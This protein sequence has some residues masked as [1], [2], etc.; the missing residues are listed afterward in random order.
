MAERVPVNVQGIV[1]ESLA[2]L[3]AS[4]PSHI[5]VEKKLEAPSWVLGDPT[6]LHQVVMN[7]CTNAIRAMEDDGVLTI[8]LDEV[9]VSE[10]RVV[11]HGT[12]LPAAYVRLAVSD[13]GTGIPPQVLE[14]IF[15]PFFTTRGVGEGTGLG[16]ALVHGIVADVQGAV[17]VLTRM[18][19]GTTFTIWLPATKESAK[20]A[21]QVARD[22]ARGAGE[23]IMIVDDELALVTLAE[24][25]L[26]ELGYEPVG[27]D[28]SVAAL[29]AFRAEPSRFDAVL[30]DETMP[31][32]AGIQLARE[33]RRLRAGPTC[34]SDERLQ[35][36]AVCGTCPGR[37]RN[38]GAAQNR[39]SESRH[40]RTR[41][42]ERCPQSGMQP[43]RPS[44]TALAP[45]NTMSF[46][47]YA[48]LLRAGL[49]LG[50]PEHRK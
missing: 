26:A 50:R 2:L 3:A 4:L 49:E 21:P 30:T 48:R 8:A 29:Q 16:L 20:A 36:R 46:G 41:S 22:L 34:H 15:D 9:Q 39:S 6:Q 5:R 18:G 42:R 19:K 14:R 13:T 44:P 32:L 43:D 40:R 7:L 33:V 31:E 23:C 35:R 45:A 47:P 37:R 24:E 25:T 27:F 38:R 12:L 10:R 1:E 17:D 11:S 28:S